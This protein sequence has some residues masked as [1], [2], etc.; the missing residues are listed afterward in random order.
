LLY[1]TERHDYRTGC[2][3]ADCHGPIRTHPIRIMT[4]EPDI[5]AP[6]TFTAY[7]EGRDPAMEAIAADIRRSASKLD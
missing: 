1:A 5:P 6:L 3:E 7:R 4:L 2:Q